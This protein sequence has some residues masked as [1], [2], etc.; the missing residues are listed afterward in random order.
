M[1]LCLA[2]PAVSYMPPELLID[3]ELSPAT[4]A[5]SFGV[6]LWELMSGRRA[7]RGMGPMQIMN[8][9]TL[10]KRTLLVP[11]HWPADV[12]VGGLT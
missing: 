5:F 8:A 9:V 10:E 3:D 2:L 4:D 6:V 12:K 11:D 1:P 7:W